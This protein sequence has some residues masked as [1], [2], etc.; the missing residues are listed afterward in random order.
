V[1]GTHDILPGTVESNHFDFIVEKA[2]SVA[3]HFCYKRIQTPI[4]EH[5]EVFKR[6]LGEDSD[7]VMK[8]M[9]TFSTARPSDDATEADAAKNE[10]LITL[11]PENTAS[12][13]RALLNG[14][15]ELQL[16][17]KV[18][19][20]GPMFRHERP[21]RGRYR[22]FHQFGIENI[23]SD[24]FHAD[25]EALSLAYEFLKHIGVVDYTTVRVVGWPTNFLL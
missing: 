22:Q 19:Y 20:Y 9:F 4:L 25:V 24:H 15:L 13:V 6:T 5:T 12:V 8:E 10:G 23:G 2:T 14:N 11:R 17:Q 1:R 16:P 3:E 21:Q 18:F 7:V